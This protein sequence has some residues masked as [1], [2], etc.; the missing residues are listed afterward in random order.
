MHR[1]LPNTFSV[2]LSS[3]VAGPR[4]QF[5]ARLCRA[6]GWMASLYSR[7]VSVGC[8]ERNRDLL[9]GHSS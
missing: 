7:A 9:R 6:A 1:F 2:P 3:A 5:S 8:A 4:A